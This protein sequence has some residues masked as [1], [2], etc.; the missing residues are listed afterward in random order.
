[1][2]IKNMIRMAAVVIGFAG[3]LLLTSSVQAQEITNVEFPDSSG[4]TSAFQAAPATAANSANT[5]AANAQMMNAATTASKSMDV[6][7]AAVSQ[8]PAGAW[9]VALLLI[10]I[11]GIALYARADAK[12]ANRTFTSRTVQTGRSV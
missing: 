7:V 9:P 1:M 6:Q 4:A 12:R 5:A 3:A 2:K 8:I 10:G 11:A